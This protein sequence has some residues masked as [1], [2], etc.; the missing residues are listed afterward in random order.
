MVWRSLVCYGVPD[1]EGDG[2]EQMLT[3]GQV[4]ERL[5]VNEYT[6][7]RWLRSGELEGTPFGGRTGWRV[8]EEALTAFLERRRTARE[9][10]K[11]AA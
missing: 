8:T 10:G 2:M 9:T 11:A 5:Q 4:A 1:V 6:V 3:V 7:R